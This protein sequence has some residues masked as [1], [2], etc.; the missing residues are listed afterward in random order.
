MVYISKDLWGIFF[1]SKR[2]SEAVFFGLIMMPFITAAMAFIAYK[3]IGVNNFKASCL[4]IGSILCLMATII[5]Y[6]AFISYMRAYIRKNGIIQIWK[7]LHS[8]GIVFVIVGIMAGAL[9]L[10]MR[11]IAKAGDPYIP[12]INRCLIGCLIGIGIGV[13]FILVTRKRQNNN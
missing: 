10:F 9:F 6:R 11:L 4:G 5:H 3:S 13:L 12:I 8:Y 1:M 7:D 2:E